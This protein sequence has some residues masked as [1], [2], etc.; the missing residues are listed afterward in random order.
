MRSIQSFVV[1]YD[2][3]VHADA[4]LEM[5]MDLAERFDA[6]L[7]LLH[8]VQPATYS[9]AGEYFPGGPLFDV[10]AQAEQ[11]LNEIAADLFTPP[12][13]VEAHV[14]AGAGV[15][16][17]LDAQAGQLGADLIV[18]GTHG[19]TGLAHV[20]YGSVAERTLRRAP[21]P[22]LTVPLPKQPAEVGTPI[23]NPL[24]SSAVSESF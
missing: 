12:K 18:M 1:T 11:R 2:F 8:V 21:C 22:V 5:A 3:S 13:R 17:T 15:P 23:R 4:A 14:V 19:R 24:A 9:Y 6:D 20:V 10:H 7:H 16:D